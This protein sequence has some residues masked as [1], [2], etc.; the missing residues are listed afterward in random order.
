LK[1]AVNKPR[2]ALPITMLRCLCAKRL[3]M[4]AHDLMERALLGMTRTIAEGGGH[5]TAVRRKARALWVDGFPA[6]NRVATLDHRSFCV[7]A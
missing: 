6:A 5:D 7:P 1:R 2:Q 4:L 3:E